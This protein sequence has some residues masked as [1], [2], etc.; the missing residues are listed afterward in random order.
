MTYFWRR[1][2]KPRDTW[3]ISKEERN[4]ERMETLLKLRRKANT[5]IT[6]IG[7]LYYSG[8]YQCKILEDTWRDPDGS[9]QLEADEKVY[10]ET[11]IPVGTYRIRFAYSPSWKMLMPY[12]EDV[13][14]YSGVMFHPGNKAV[15]TKGC[16]LTGTTMQKDLVLNSKDAFLELIKKLIEDCQDKEVKIEVVNAFGAEFEK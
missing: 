11:A 16:L 5:P 2:H 15:D 3:S 7:D 8:I 10:G 6:A 9:G 4:V 12:L 1:I 14:H 13:P